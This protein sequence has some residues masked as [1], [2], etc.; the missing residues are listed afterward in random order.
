MRPL[1]AGCGSTDRVTTTTPTMVVGAQG[2]TKAA[3]LD[4]E[5]GA[6]TVFARPVWDTAT[7]RYNVVATAG[8]RSL[9]LRRG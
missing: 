7:D 9:T 5:S 6:S 8:V 1:I 4:V 2:G 3:E